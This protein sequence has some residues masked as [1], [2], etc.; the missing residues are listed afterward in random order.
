MSAS[1]SLANRNSVIIDGALDEW[2]SLD[3]L[4]YPPTYTPGFNLCAQIE[5]QFLF[6]ALHSDFG[7]VGAATTFWLNANQDAAAAGHFFAN[8]K[9][10]AT[11]P[12]GISQSIIEMASG[13]LWRDPKGGSNGGGV[14]IA[15]LSGLPSVAAADLIVIA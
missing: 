1:I 5:G 14:S 11:G 13:L 12:A 9:S 8:S 7:T 6:F 4:G 10:A 2:S 15:A 3:R